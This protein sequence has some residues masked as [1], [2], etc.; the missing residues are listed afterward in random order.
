MCYNQTEQIQNVHLNAREC[1][2]IGLGCFIGSQAKPAQV[3]RI[4][5]IGVAPPTN[6]LHR[7]HEAATTKATLGPSLDCREKNENMTRTA[8][9][10][11]S[12]PM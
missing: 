4:S 1:E 7:L 8:T 5:P 3:R 9:T 6:S 10:R 2:P 11:V 12:N